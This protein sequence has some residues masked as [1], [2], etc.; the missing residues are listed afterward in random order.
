MKA[1]DPVLIPSTFVFAEFY[2]DAA[3]FGKTTGFELK[4]EVK[5]KAGNDLP[6]N[7]EHIVEESGTMTVSCSR[8][9][10]AREIKIIAFNAHS[11]ENGTSSPL[12]VESENVAASGM[13]LFKSE[14]GNYSSI[15]W[16]YES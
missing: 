12:I 9:D 15:E 5:Y 16:Y 3:T 13:S 14:A 8:D 4:W 7:V 11:R 2:T 10:L 1:G 6:V